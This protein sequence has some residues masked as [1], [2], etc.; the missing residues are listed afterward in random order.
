MRTGCGVF[1]VSHMGEIAD[2]GAPRRSTSC[3]A[4]CPTT[5]RSSRWAAPSTRC[6][7][8]TTAGVLDDLFTYRLADDRY[9]TVT[10]AANHERDFAWFV[11]HA[12][13]LRRA[14]SPTRS[15]T[16]RCSRCRARRRARS[17]RASLD[18]ELP[19]RMRTADVPFADDGDPGLRHRL[20]RRGRRRDPAAAGR[21]DRALGRARSRQG[22]LRRASAPGT[23][24]AWRS[25]STS[26]ATTWTTDRD[27]IERRPGLVLQGGD[28]LH[29]LRGGRRASAPTGRPRSSPRSCSP[30]PASRARATRSSPTASRW[31]W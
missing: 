17:R 14:R 12:D 8:V 31:A 9:L 23:R 6:S 27:P 10:N 2:L 18:G 25:A 11:E 13:G 3:S 30:A 26:T 7:A 15:T 1:D 20:H 21:G 4:C 5:S 28:G 24:C 19:P 16:T 29:R 22:P